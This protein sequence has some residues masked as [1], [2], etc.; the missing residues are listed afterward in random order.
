MPYRGVHKSLPQ[1]ARELNVDAVIDGYG[2]AFQRAS[3]DHRS[4]DSGADRQTFVVPEL[5][6]RFKGCAGVTVR[7]RKCHCE[8]GPVIAAVGIRTQPQAAND[9]MRLAPCYS[10]VAKVVCRNRHDRDE[11]QEKHSDTCARMEET[12]SA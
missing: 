1:V 8:I 11:E 6:E 4:V 7:N 10:C 5:P 3:K 12:S 2:R 9:R